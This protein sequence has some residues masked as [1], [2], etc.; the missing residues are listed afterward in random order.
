MND[1][2]NYNLKDWWDWNKNDPIGDLIK[3]LPPEGGKE[4]PNSPAQ[5]SIWDEWKKKQLLDTKRNNILKEWDEKFQEKGVSVS[6]DE[7]TGDLRFHLKRVPNA[8][9]SIATPSEEKDGFKIMY[10]KDMLS[11]IYDGFTGTSNYDPQWVLYIDWKIAIKT[12]RKETW[13]SPED[14]K[15][16]NEVRKRY[17]QNI[18]SLIEKLKVN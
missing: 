12:A 8:I 7:W 3:K 2:P 4:I 1:R 16:K 9:F 6:Y 5:P 11:L 18:H 13:I 14:L 15:S 10:L 17:A